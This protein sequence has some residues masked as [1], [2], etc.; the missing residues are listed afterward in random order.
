MAKVRELLANNVKRFRGILGISQIEFAEKVGCSPTL[1]GKIESTKRFP[2]A[3]T[4]DRIAEALK[5]SPADLF[6]ENPKIIQEKRKSRII[7]RLIKVIN[8]EI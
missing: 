2:T 3:N 1:I 5:V 4:I 6:V 7:N 8:E